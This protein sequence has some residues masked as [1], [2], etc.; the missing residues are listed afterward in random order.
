LPWRSWYGLERWKKR[1]RHQL[2]LEPLCRACLARGFV[3]PAT[4]AD[5]EPPH[6]GNWN[7]FRLGP[8]QSL[9]ADCHAGKWAA[10]RRGSHAEIG[11]RGDIGDDGWPTDPRHPANRTGSAR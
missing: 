11:Y 3:V 1:A 4:I 10:D 5:H 8:L 2:R 7:A 9:C 6:R